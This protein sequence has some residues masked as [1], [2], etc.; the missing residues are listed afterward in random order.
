MTISKPR[1]LNLL[2][3]DDEPDLASSLS[4]ILKTRG[5]CVETAHDG[6]NAVEWARDHEPDGVLMDI[7]MPGIN[8]VEAFRRIRALHPEAFVIFMT[9]HSELVREAQNERPIAVMSKP[10]DPGQICDLIDGAPNLEAD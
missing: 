2:V 4:R 6:E 1:T 8:G 5:F 3:V 9:G 7:R 10:V